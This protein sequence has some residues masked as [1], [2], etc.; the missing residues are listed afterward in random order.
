MNAAH[1]RARC[2]A[3]PPR[4]GARGGFT[5]GAE[6]AEL[7]PHCAPSR[8]ITA[9]PHR[10]S[11]EIPALPP[12]PVGA[13]QDRVPPSLSA[14]PLSPF[15]GCRAR[16]SGG[17]VRHKRQAL[18]DMARPLKQWLYKHRDN[19]YP[20]KTEKILLALGSQMTLVQV[21]DPPSGREGR[22]QPMLGPQVRSGSSAWPGRAGRVLPSA[23][24]QHRPVPAWTVKAES[25]ETRVSPPPLLGEGAAS[26]ISS[27][28]TTE[29]FAWALKNFRV[30]QN[31]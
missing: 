19:P 29:S 10:P 6:R 21:R 4:A 18:Q 9:V 8:S 7:G 24:L 11:T 30:P 15:L 27:I 12:L 25:S 23:A 1:R 14:A 3:S 22:G 16:Q 31:Q 28:S 5:A 26:F 2:R 20:T 13:S 17:K